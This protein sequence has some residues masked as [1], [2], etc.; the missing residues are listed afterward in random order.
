MKVKGQRISVISTGIGTDN[1]DIVMN[2]LDAVVNID[3]KTKRPREHMR[4]LNIVRIG[5]SGTLREDIPLDLQWFL[6]MPLDLTALY[7]SIR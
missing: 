6:H 3:F 7:I 4:S 5:T 2:E 1:M